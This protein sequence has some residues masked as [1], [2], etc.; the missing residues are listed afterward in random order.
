M[1]ERMTIEEKTLYK[2]KTRGNV[3]RSYSFEKKQKVFFDKCATLYA[4]T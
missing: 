1:N 3:S 2:N 4:D